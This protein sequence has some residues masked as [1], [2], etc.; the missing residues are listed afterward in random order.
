MAH[1]GT[2]DDAHLRTI[3]SGRHKGKRV[4]CCD[5]P[6]CLDDT[7]GV[8]CTCPDCDTEACGVHAETTTP[9]GTE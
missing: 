4:C 8:T 9:G 1:I 3:L 7:A 6:D 2:T 5:C